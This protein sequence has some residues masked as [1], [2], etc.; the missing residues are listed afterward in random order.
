MRFRRMY[1]EGG[2]LGKRCIADVKEER[3]FVIWKVNALKGLYS[4]RCVCNR[5]Y[6]VILT[7]NNFCK[8][9][10]NMNT[11]VASPQVPSLVCFTNVYNNLHTHTHS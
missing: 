9:Q 7:D 3:L 2:R 11:Q 5:Q 4:Q 1:P 8:L 10:Y 6:L